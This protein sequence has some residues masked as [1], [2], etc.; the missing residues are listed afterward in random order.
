MEKVNEQLRRELG[1]ILLMEMSDPRFELVSITYVETSPDLRYA[2]V[3]FSVMGDE[4]KINNAQ[5]GLN[6]ARNKIRSLV[7]QRIKMRYIPEIN[8]FYDKSIE[9]SARI[10]E[11]LKE[12]K[13]ENKRDT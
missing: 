11:A 3:F 2:K 4:E 5:Q 9:Y 7:A 13:D 1:T 8:F 6:N 10:E 12:I